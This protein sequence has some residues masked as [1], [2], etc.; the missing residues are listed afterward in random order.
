MRHWKAY[1]LRAVPFLAMLGVLAGCGGGA[2]REAAYVDRLPLPID[3]MTTRMI[4]PGV[5]G[6]RFVF[7]ST[8]GPKTFNAIMANETSTTDITQRLFAALTDIDYITQDD[9]GIL[10]KS[11]ETSED[12]LTT[13]FH[14]RRGLA[15][16]DG[17]RL[18]SEDVEFS[19]GVVMDPELHASTQDGRTS[20]RIQATASAPNSFTFVTQP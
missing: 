17:H 20:D 10:A 7:G 3:T 19:L 5:Y 4:E 8:S 2:K 18:T 13:T 6:G 16:S 1:S 14:L 9:I 15:F 11:W 12:G